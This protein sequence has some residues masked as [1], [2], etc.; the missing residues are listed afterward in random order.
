MPSRSTTRPE[1]AR[2]AAPRHARGFVLPAAIFLIVIMAA[3][4]AF[5]ARITV[6]ANTAS[7]QDMQGAR[8]LQ[9]ARAG[10]E[11]GLYAV[12][13]GGNCPGGTLVSPAGFNGF[14]VVWA[15]SAYPFADG[16]SNHTLWQITST[17]CYTS[18]ACPSSDAAEVAGADYTE[19]QLV[20][21]TEA[22]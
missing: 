15:C 18:G 3:L 6:A 10:I 1:R 22:P 9:A 5:I 19:R 4:G 20:A 16:G 14:R 13:V 17:A 12:R 7:G 21:L 11:A 2:L 8:A